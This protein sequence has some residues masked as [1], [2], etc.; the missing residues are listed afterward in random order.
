LGDVLLFHATGGR[1]R[2]GD[3]VVELLGPFLSA[4]LGDDGKVWTPLGLPNTVLFRARKPGRAEIDVITG[5]ALHSPRTTE[6]SVD[7]EP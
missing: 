7:V 2:S 5:D 6:L 4:V 3:D 1:I